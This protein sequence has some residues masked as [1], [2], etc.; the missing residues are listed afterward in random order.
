LI[1]WKVAL[2]LGAISSRPAVARP[3]SITNALVPLLTPLAT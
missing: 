3:N 2:A 1:R